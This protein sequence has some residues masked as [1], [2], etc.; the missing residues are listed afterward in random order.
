MRNETLPTR[1][2]WQWDGLT[3]RGQKA[4]VGYYVL[5]VEL[6]TPSGTKR[7]FR[8]TVVVGARL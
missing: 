5:L 8:K 2:F 4:A 6:F 1:G 7:E 3:D